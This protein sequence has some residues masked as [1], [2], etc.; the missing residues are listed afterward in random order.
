VSVAA[1]QLLH[2]GQVLTR[3]EEKHQAVVGTGSAQSA[4]D[5]LRKSILA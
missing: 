4:S 2:Q 5:L 3:L 1:E